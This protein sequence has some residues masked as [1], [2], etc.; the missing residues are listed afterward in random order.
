ME[1]DHGVAWKISGNGLSL[2]LFGEINSGPVISMPEGDIGRGNVRLSAE[3]LIC[4]YASAKNFVNERIVNFDTILRSQIETLRITE[5]C[6]DGSNSS[7]S[8]S[9]PSTVLCSLLGLLAFRKPTGGHRFLGRFGNVHSNLGNA[10]AIFSAAAAAAAHHRLLWIHPFLDG[11]G[12]VARLMSYAMLNVSLD[13]GGGW[14]IAR[15]LA[16]QESRHKQHLTSC[17]QPRSRD[18]DGRGS[19][20]E[21]VLADFTEFSLP[22][23]F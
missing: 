19:R 3:S 12:R 1:I 17:D 22:D 21:A 20:S 2:N 10:E 4:G 8:V 9:A 14:S 5:A 15:G 11:K 7:V 23:R 6:T 13:T 18:P 16:R